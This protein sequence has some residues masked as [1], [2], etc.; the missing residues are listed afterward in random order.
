M[1]RKWLSIL[2]MITAVFL[3]SGCGLFGPD[4][5][6]EPQPVDPPQMT[7]DKP[8]GPSSEVINI[9][10]T[11][12]SNEGKVEASD[13]ETVAM[14]VYLLD[15]DG[16]VVPVTLD[17]PK[18][19]GSAKQVLNYMVQGGPIEELMPN[20]F[21]ALLPEGTKILGMTIKEGVATVDFSPEFKNYSAD[22]EQK[23]VDGITFALTSFPSIKEVRV[24]INGYPQEVMP[25]GGTPVSSLSRENGINRELAENIHIGNTTPVTLFFQAQNDEN[26]T[27]FVPV[28][29]MIPRTDNLAMAT[30][31][32]LI[33][34]PK[35]GTDLFT[36]ILPSTKVLNVKADNGMAVVDFDEQILSYSDGMANPLAMRSL[37]LS[38][39]ENTQV[40]KVQFMVNGE[41][42][43]L[44]GDQDYTEPVARPVQ[45]N[46]IEM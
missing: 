5:A 28:T 13:T 7:Q 37:V 20:G 36:S 32:Q 2:S 11:P 35:L 34:G 1:T 27:Y 31:E 14:P 19:E 29:R 45:L 39:T 10:V 38:L 3:L 24:W 18:V 16:Y 26:L 23:I 43:V 15:P 46:P 21:S 30:V 4:E 25:V 42:K 9:D 8:L 12:G 33:R 17:L 22:Q 41:A 6:T 44:A 40:Q